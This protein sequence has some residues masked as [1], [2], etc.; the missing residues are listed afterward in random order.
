MTTTQLSQTEYR[1]LR[2]FLQWATGEAVRRV[3][4]FGEKHGPETLQDISEPFEPPV[5]EDR[6]AEL[7]PSIMLLMR[8]A[9]ESAERTSTSLTTSADIAARAAVTIRENLPYGERERLLCTMARMLI[10]GE[11]YD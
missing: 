9:L 3:H 7:A 11:G 8:Q 4:R 1:T 5:S 10:N 6:A 2:T